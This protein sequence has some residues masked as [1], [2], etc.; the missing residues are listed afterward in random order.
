M[1][2][3]WPGLMKAG[4]STRHS[5]ET[6]AVIDF[7]R[8]SFLL[9]DPFIQGHPG[10]GAVAIGRAHFKFVNGMYLPERDPLGIAFADRL[11]VGAGEVAGI[12]VKVTGHS[13]RS[14]ER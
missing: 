10:P 11:A 12:E 14:E 6:D 9:L 4:V 5:S 8:R 13:Y 3:T 1:A 2:A 7:S